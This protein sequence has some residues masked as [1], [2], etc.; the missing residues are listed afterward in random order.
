MAPS[1][2]IACVA[3]NVAKPGPGKAHVHPLCCFFGPNFKLN[4]NLAADAADRPHTADTSESMRAA[5]E[6]APHRD[7]G[8]HCGQGMGCQRQWTVTAR[9]ALGGH[10]RRGVPSLAAAAC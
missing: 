4:P 2:A 5:G 10:G 1:P 9:A 8:R 6:E 3:T 7:C